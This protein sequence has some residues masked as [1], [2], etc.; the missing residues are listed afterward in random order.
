[1]IV[2]IINVRMIAIGL[3]KNN[4]EKALGKGG[5]PFGDLPCAIKGKMYLF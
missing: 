4:G 3:R 1:M 2:K 5:V